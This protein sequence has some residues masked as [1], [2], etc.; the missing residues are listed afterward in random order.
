M[1]LTGY[2]QLFR[3]LADTSYGSV[4]FYFFCFKHPIFTSQYLFGFCFVCVCVCCLFLRITASFELV[5]YVGF[6]CAFVLVILIKS[7]LL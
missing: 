6:L 5:C 1:W 7:V 2:E 4:P 3:G